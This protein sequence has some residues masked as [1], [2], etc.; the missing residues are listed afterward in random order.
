ME[1]QYSML[2]MSLGSKS[3]GRRLAFFLGCPVLLSLP[4]GLFQAGFA[5]HLS[6]EVAVL[7]WA[8]AWLSMWWMSE[9]FLRIVH[10]VLRP[11]NMALIAEITL[12]NILTIIAYSFYFPPIMFLFAEHATDLPPDF[13][14]ARVAR[15]SLEH[16]F[17]MARSGLSG[18][19]A[20]VLL[21]SLYAM[22][23]DRTARKSGHSITDG[24]I[25]A[26]QNYPLSKFRRELISKGVTDL[27]KVI[28]LQA[29]DHYVTVFLDDGSKEFILARFSDAIED[30]AEQ[31][32][33][34][35]H[36]SFWINRRAIDKVER[37]GAALTTHL[38]NGLSCPV[39]IKYQGY[40]EH[41]LAK[42]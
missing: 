10:A 23:P 26:A 35:I 19:I 39:S 38:T 41:F 17:L 15:G 34:R 20:W 42:A 25:P 16:I 12:A 8:F 18:L 21:R 3:W 13:F 1:R 24:N 37:S 2:S 5:Q 29:S 32:G 40:F 9:V 4:L 14:E 33:L 31:D 11:W 36:R 6:V 30:L 28:A 7:F 22:L 27:D